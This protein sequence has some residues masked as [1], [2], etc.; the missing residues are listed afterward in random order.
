M[1]YACTGCD[2][3][4]RNPSPD[5]YV[6]AGEYYVFC[7]G[8]CIAIPIPEIGCSIS[9]LIAIAAESLAISI[10]SSK[11]HFCSLRKTLEIA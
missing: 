11:L 3:C 4:V 10:P 8:N 1:P 5:H 6:P 2:D 9:D 7:D